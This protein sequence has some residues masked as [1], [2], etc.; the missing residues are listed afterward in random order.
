MCKT[1]HSGGLESSE[2]QTPGCLNIG[3]RNMMD[4]MGN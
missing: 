3:H 1:E 2:L 4:G